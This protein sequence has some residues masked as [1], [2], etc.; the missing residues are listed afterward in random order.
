MRTLTLGAQKLAN[1][2]GQLDDGAK[3]LADG[4]NS[5]NAGAK[6]LSGVWFGGFAARKSGHDISR[7]Q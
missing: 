2:V 4:A 3:S 6:K 1:G 7:L 5:A